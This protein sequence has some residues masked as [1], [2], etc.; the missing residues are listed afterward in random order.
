MEELI[1][2]D[3]PLDSSAFFEKLKV[4][5]KKY[6][7]ESG[8][9]K[10][11]PSITYAEYR[12][13]SGQPIYTKLRN[14]IEAVRKHA[15]YQDRLRAESSDERTRKL[16]KQQQQQQ[17]EVINRKQEKRRAKENR[18]KEK[19]QRKLQQ[20]AQARAK[21]LEA[22]ESSARYRGA[23]HATKYEVPYRC[24]PI[25]KPNRLPYT[26]VPFT[27]PLPPVEH[28]RP[29][30]P[31]YTTTRDSFPSSSSLSF[32]S[33]SEEFSDTKFQPGDFVLSTINTITDALNAAS[34]WCTTVLAQWDRY[35]QRPGSFIK[36]V[37]QAH[38]NRTKQYI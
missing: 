34:R 31:P 28:H 2:A 22:Q 12:E 17:N 1:E 3:P 23:L 6:P 7:T 18:E 30:R 38:A 36:I 4:A 27:K 10:H 37:G 19:A 13:R 25:R 21:E 29:A 35:V 33:S 9:M 16:T 15:R 11:S 14:E 5:G 8:S 26:P 24:P 20:E 32:S